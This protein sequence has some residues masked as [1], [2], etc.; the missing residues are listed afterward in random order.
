M[1]GVEGVVGTLDS[2]P[3]PWSLRHGGPD[4]SSCEVDLLLEQNSRGNG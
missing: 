3:K 4:P 1:R 2:H